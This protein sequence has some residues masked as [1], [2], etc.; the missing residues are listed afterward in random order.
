MSNRRPDH[1]WYMSSFLV[2]TPPERVDRENGIIYGAAIVTA[3]EAKGHDVWLDQEFV[4]NVARMGNEKRQGLHMRFGHPTMSSTALGTFLARAK[5]FRVDGAIARADMY[6]SASAKE[7][8]QGDLHKYVLTLAQDESDMFGTSIVFEPGESFTKDGD[9]RE[10][11][12]IDKLLAADVV[13]SPAANDG[14]FSQWNQATLAGQV[15]EFLDT[16]PRV[17]EIIHEHP[18]VID[19][20]MARYEAFRLSRGA[21]D[22]RTEDAMATEILSP[23]DEDLAQLDIAAEAA[24]SVAEDAPEQLDDT[25]E[26]DDTAETVELEADDEIEAAVALSDLEAMVTSFGADLTCS[27]LLNGGD[28]ADARAMYYE[29]LEADNETLREALETQRTELDAEPVEFAD[30]E[31]TAPDTRKYDN[32]LSPALAQYA[33]HNAA[34]RAQ[35]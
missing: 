4:E 24:P 19:D 7:S 10:Y 25:P 32:K 26:T 30:A 16:H 21:P 12:T 11:A 35:Q 2:G 31:D 17:L 14:L 22:T 1:Q 15:S 6:L 20:F 33:A 18:E 3:G 29:R 5:N 34:N 9:D 8:P 13:D 28:Y 23:A 27:V